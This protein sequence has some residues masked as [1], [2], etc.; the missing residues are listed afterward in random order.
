MPK[1]FEDGPVLGDVLISESP[2]E[3]G[4]E[5]VKITNPTNADFKLPV[6]YPLK[7]DG[8]PI[9]AADI[10]L[11][12]GLL[13]KPCFLFDDGAE[14]YPMLARGPAVV[15]FTRLPTVDYLNAAINA[16]AFKAALAGLGI[17]LRYEAPHRTTQTT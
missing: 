6:G 7:A 15:N 14:L 1:T 4:R 17:V 5:S 3:F 12:G 16:D 2:I 13:V 10:A 8:T 11:L 9:V